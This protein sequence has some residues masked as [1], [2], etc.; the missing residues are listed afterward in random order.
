[1]SPSPLDQYIGYI[2]DG[3]RHD[4]S[5][6]EIAALIERDFSLKTSEA[7]VRRCIERHEV[8]RDCAETRNARQ[9][10][11][12]RA[13][14]ASL[15]RRD[16]EVII[17][18][19]P[20]W[21]VPVQELTH[22]ALLE[23]HKLDPEVWQ[24]RDTLINQWE[25]GVKGGGK[26]TLYQFKV[27]FKPCVPLDVLL[28]AIDPGELP[29]KPKV[30]RPVKS[31]LWVGWFDPHC[32]YHDLGLYELG[33]RWLTH[34][35]PA[36]GLF[37][38]DGPDYPDISTRHPK[39]LVYNA[40]AQECVQSFFE[41]MRGARFAS[42]DTEW[43]YIEGNHDKRVQKLMIER[44]TDLAEL[45]PAAWPEELPEQEV[46]Y[47]PSYL[48]HLDKLGV[49]YH[50]TMNNY[51]FVQVEV[52]PGLGARHGT[53]HGRD[54]LQK[55]AEKYGHD[56]IYG[57]LHRRALYTETRWNTLDGTKQTIT[58]VQA[59]TMAEISGGLGHDTAPDWNQGFV[60][61]QVFES[62]N[63]SIEFANYEDGVL[64]WRDQEY[65]L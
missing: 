41:F 26:Q 8:L 43:D 65:V 28:P 61:A 20:S 31:W 29:P 21:D 32:P 25:M 64:T 55:H 51:E 49:N 16:G 56:L 62:G 35:K 6:V 22:E 18:E 39:R 63:Y 15:E 11:Y 34:N 19:K 7:S 47:S 9:S 30:Y 36:R 60:T 53:F 17:T 58:T 2:A 57:H 52:T 3:L 13:E 59:P 5:N 44:A 46:I 42:S 12:E 38:G 14:P 37:G 45:K 40:S 23:R 4:L 33:L 48:F 27:W 1:M 24:V 10:M 50:A 54:A